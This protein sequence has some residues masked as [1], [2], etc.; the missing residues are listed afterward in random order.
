MSDSQIICSVVQVLICTSW[1]LVA[2][3]SQ[4]ARLQWIIHLS[5]ERN[6]NLGLRLG[7]Y[8]L[9]KL[10]KTGESPRWHAKI[11]VLMM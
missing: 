7:R 11:A 2:Y 9:L 5:K 1:Q 3:I 4:E 8:M 10:E 6:M